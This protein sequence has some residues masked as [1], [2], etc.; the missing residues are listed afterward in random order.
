QRHAQYVF[1]SYDLSDLLGEALGNNTR[2]K[3]GEQ[4][5]VQELTQYITSHIHPGTWESQGGTAGIDYASGT[6]SLVVRHAEATQEEVATLLESRRTLEQLG[7]KPLAWLSKRNAHD[8]QLTGGEEASS[9]RAK[10]IDDLSLTSAQGRQLHE[11]DELLQ[12]CHFALVN[13]SKE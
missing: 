1:G 8:I 4:E 2:D 9:E 7:K 11:V 6:T 12:Q 3:T 13:G 5:M 10:P